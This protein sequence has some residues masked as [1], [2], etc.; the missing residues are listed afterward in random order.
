MFGDGYKVSNDY[1]VMA[2]DGVWLAKI[3]DVEIRKTK[4]GC[5]MAVIS[6]FMEK[7]GSIYYF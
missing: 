4:K 1:S 6:L 7:N 5:E 2:R 3:K